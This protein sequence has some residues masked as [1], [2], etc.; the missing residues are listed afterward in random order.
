MLFYLVPL[1]LCS[2]MVVYLAFIFICYKCYPVYGIFLYSTKC[3]NA[4]VDSC[5]TITGAFVVNLQTCV[6]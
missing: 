4:I 6:T 3:Y 1:S 2:K 5:K